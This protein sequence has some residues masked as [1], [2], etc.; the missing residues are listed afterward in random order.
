MSDEGGR[1]SEGGSP[2]FGPRGRGR[3]P[4]LPEACARCGREVGLPYHPDDWVNR[5]DPKTPGG[6]IALCPECAASESV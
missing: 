1:R 2:F 6:V 5:L 3:D 4:R